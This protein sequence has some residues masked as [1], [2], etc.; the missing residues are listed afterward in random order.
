MTVQDI[1]SVGEGLFASALE[2]VEVV[3]EGLTA[4][5]AFWR[6]TVEWLDRRA[7]DFQRIEAR[8]V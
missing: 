7:K 6:A 4:V 5:G 3:V 1:A 8:P 2:A